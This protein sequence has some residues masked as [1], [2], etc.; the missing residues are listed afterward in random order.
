MLSQARRAVPTAATAA[1]RSGGAL[2][3]SGRLWEEALRRRSIGL[4]VAGVVLIGPLALAADLGIANVHR[5]DGSAP[6]YL[7]NP[8]CAATDT[9]L[10]DAADSFQ[11]PE[12]HVVKVVYAHASDAP[13]QFA[14]VYPS[15]AQGVRDIVEYVYVESGER[16]SIRFDLGTPAGLDCLDAQRI[17]LPN[18]ASYYDPDNV[19]SAR[20]KVVADLQPRLGAQPG[21]RNFLVFVDGVPNN[22]RAANTFPSPADDSVAGPSW[23]VGGYYSVI[24]DNPFTFGLSQAFGKIG[25]HELF[26]TFGAVQA[27][28]PHHGGGGHCVERQDL[29][30]DPGFGGPVLCDFGDYPT[31]S[32]ETPQG[33]LDCGGDDYFN[34]APAPGSYLATHWNTFNS[35]FLCPVGTCVPDNVAPETRI[36]GPKRTSDRTPRFRLRSDEDG[37][38]FACKLDRRRLRPCGPRY[39]PPRLAAG[40]HK[41]RATAT[42]AAGNEDQSAAVKR[43]KVRRKRVADR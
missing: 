14:Q 17:S 21:Q 15:L 35:P 27:S 2:L 3:Y 24:F 25:V 36:K 34:P 19:S 28:A 9:P 29:M 32:W 39:A 6:A 31:I 38:E 43:F 26:H 1:S 16:K 37:V 30:C 18:P 41:L 10:D 11:P 42:D 8:D 23:Q 40:R 5:V 33:R 12:A 20:Q 13:N 22:F 4:V 7:P